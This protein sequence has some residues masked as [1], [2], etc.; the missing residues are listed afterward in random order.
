MF[1]LPESLPK[2]LIKLLWSIRRTILYQP[3]NYLHNVKGE[4]IRFFSIMSKNIPFNSSYD[5]HREEAM[6]NK[7]LEPDYWTNFLNKEAAYLIIEDLTYKELARYRFW[8]REVILKAWFDYILEG[9]KKQKDS[10]VFD[11]H[12]HKLLGY[13]YNRD[14]T[15][16]TLIIS[17]YRA[18]YN[19]IN[20]LTCLFSSKQ[21]KSEEGYHLDHLLPW[22]FYPINRFWNLY[23]C[24]SSINIQKSNNL[25][26][27]SPN[28]EEKIR[29]HLYLCLQY[30]TSPLVAN[31][32]RYFYH[33]NQ[34]NTTIEI[35]TRENSKILKEL[36]TFLK[37][38]WV[39]LYE[40]MPGKLF[41]SELI[42]K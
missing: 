3:L 8:A 42:E 41:K 16:D 4:I 24:E 23:P 17:R 26:E 25:P 32:L 38:E 37:Q 28:L 27:W 10:L 11:I 33:V 18:F 36:I 30:K 1:D 21:F 22:S 14:L 7:K 39:N 29:G 31:D 2:S 40:I 34:K 12:I 35:E 20:A 9:E 15:R 19:Q 13:I 5:M 6:R